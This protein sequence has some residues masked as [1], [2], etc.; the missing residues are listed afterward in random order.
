[1]KHYA[2][3]EFNRAKLLGTFESG[4]PEWHA[5]RAEGIGGSEVGTILGL[6]PWESAY[7]LHHLKT[8]ELP[9]KQIDSFPAWLGSA[10]EPFILGPMMQKMH[11]EIEVFTT[12]T[13]QHPALPFLHANPDALGKIGDEWIVIEAKTSRN[14]WAEVP[15]AYV[16]Q[17]QH[18]LNIMGLKRGLLIGLVG[19]DPVEYWIEAD[20]FEQGAIEQ[21]ATQFWLGLEKKQPPTW[22]GSDSTFQAVRQLHP[23]IDGSEVEIDGLH[24]L[25]FAQHKFDEAE[26]EL[27]KQKSEILSLMGSAQHAYIEHEGQKIRVASRQARGDGKPFL[28][29][30]KGAKI[31]SVSR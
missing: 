6:N 25:V 21:V 31:A 7:Y 17:V 24:L 4:S 10:L 11:P 12:G 26:A 23:D 13:Y 2:P 18:Y 5:V 22:D 19:M 15:P 28:V 20:E 1:M 27:R 29:I 9:Q 16:S 14:Y 3:P 8:G 30:Q